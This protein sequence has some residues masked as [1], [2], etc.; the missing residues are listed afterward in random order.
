MASAPPY[1]PADLKDLA[2]RI[3]YEA[4]LLEA[5][6]E[7]T[8]AQ[9][10]F[11]EDGFIYPPGGGPPVCIAL[12][13][14][15]IK[16]GDWRPGFLQAGAPL[17]FVTAFKILDMLIEWILVQNGQPATFR[18]AQKI[19]AVKGSKGA[20]LFP[21]TIEVRPWLRERLI[22]L[23]EHLEP[24]RGTIIH[25]R[26]FASA[27]GELDVSSSKGST[28]G[29]VVK[30]SAADL[31]NLAL[32][33]LLI[34]RHLDGSWTMDAFGEKRLRRALDELIHLHHSPS[35][36]QL[37]P[38]LLNVRVYRARTDPVEVDIGSV[39]ADIASTMSNLDVVFDLR[40]IAVERDGT[41]AESFLL[42]WDDLQVASLLMTLG[43]LAPYGVPLPADVDVMA[44]AKA[45]KFDS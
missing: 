37:P 25:D 19:A 36:G 45:M 35:L 43:Q 34:V 18:F 22:P 1:S 8:G 10:A 31:R 27:N 42:P 29:A 41:S 15:N 7:I 5:V 26:H 13:R 24:L 33:M 14:A 12:G 6:Y 44:T 17:V 16:I 21:P 20:I 28:V 39:R 23:Y 2:D 38:A 4:W 9:L 3:Q 11:D 32:V 40:I 30:I